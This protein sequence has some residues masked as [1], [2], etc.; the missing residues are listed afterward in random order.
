M[1]EV[2]GFID[3]LWYSEDEKKADE[4]KAV[5][6]AAQIKAAEA[7]VATANANAATA[8]TQSEQFKQIAMYGLI[9]LGVVVAGF[10][11][12]QALK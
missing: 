10:V 11:A 2:L 12:W 4:L 7:A 1:G 5:Q 9:G 3:D 8:A 6:A